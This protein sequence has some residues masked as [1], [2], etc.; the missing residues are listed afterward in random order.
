M[1]SNITTEKKSK[2]INAKNV[3][4]Y[5]EKKMNQKNKEEKTTLTDL[6]KQDITVKV[7]QLILIL[8]TGYFLGILFK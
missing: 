1:A 3:V 7:Y 8:A 2:D 6:L 5:G 4:I